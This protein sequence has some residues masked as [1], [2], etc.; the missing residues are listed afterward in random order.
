MSMF[1]AAE[2]IEEYFIWKAKTVIKDSL[3]HNDGRVS[4]RLK[5]L[6]VRRNHNF[7]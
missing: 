7:I 6:G 5:K 1:A 3:L 4:G 2:Q